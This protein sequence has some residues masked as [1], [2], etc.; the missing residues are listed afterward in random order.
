MS[1]VP[2]QLA[3]FSAFLLKSHYKVKQASWASREFSILF[4]F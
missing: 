2:A 1:D 4:I 3:F